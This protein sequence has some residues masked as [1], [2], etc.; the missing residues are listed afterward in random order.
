M[1]PG[2]FQL[3]TISGGEAEDRLMRRRAFYVIGL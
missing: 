1:I 3:G 2:M